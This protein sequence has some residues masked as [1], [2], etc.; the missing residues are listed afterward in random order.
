MDAASA[1]LYN[2]SISKMTALSQGVDQL[3]AKFSAVAD[4]PTRSDLEEG[5]LA[6]VTSLIQQNA[7]ALAVRD[8]QIL[9]L[10]TRVAALEAADAVNRA[11]SEAAESRFRAELA[12]M[13]ARLAASETE[14]S[15]LRPRLE[16]AHHLA[17]G[18][19]MQLDDFETRLGEMKGTSP[20]LEAAVEAATSRIAHACRNTSILDQRLTQLEQ[21]VDLTR[22][23]PDVT[24]ASAPLLPVP[25]VTPATTAL[26]HPPAPEP[27]VSVLVESVLP[28]VSITTSPAAAEP[29]AL[30]GPVPVTVTGPTKSPSPI[31]TRDKSEDV[32]YTTTVAPVAAPPIKMSAP[33]TTT[34]G[35]TADSQLVA[36]PKS[37]RRSPRKHRPRPE[38]EIQ[39]ADPQPVPQVQRPPVQRSAAPVPQSRHSRKFS[40]AHCM[41][42]EPVALS[43][44]LRATKLQTSGESAPGHAPRQ[45]L[46]LRIQALAS[47]QI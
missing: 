29:S 28:V 43:R 19:A 40:D 37:R 1:S 45:P 31:R 36:Q 39:P 5:I 18:L 15:I 4:V 8:E 23:L 46:L 41:S 35:A 44:V 34:T 22:P 11:A 20:V 38:D 16:E 17:G 2:Q 21:L 24:P 27:A 33:A 6:A 25:V 10:T 32:V 26:V 12:A 42:D 14:L 30:A 13:E 9:S 7:K 47:K 3:T